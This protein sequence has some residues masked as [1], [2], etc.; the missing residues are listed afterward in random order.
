M[1]RITV[2]I[3]IFLV[4]C[5]IPAEIFFRNFSNR[6]VRLQATL[7]DRFRFDKLPNK[8]NFYDT[9]TKSRQYAGDWQSSRLV[10]WLDTATFYIDVP[11]FTILNL[12]D[13]SR[14]LVLGARQPD[15]VLL[16]IT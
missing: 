3:S 6:K 8:V 1:W 7:V 9:A 12:A 13:I 2:L 16:M 15:V 14:G 10:T 4:G 11:P 5:T